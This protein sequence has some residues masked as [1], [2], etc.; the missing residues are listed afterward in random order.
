M[1]KIFSQT[2]LNDLEQ[3]YRVTLINSLAGF[4]QAVLI[5]TKS[6]EGQT[7]LAVFNSLIHIGSNPALYGF[8]CRPDT[9]Q[10]DT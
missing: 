4:K 5:G 9:A 8:I 3:R 6:A 2:A 1:T 10:R 7:N